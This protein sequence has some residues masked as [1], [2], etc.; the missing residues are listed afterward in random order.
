MSQNCGNQT[1]LHHHHNQT[2][3]PNC[4]KQTILGTSWHFWGTCRAPL[5]HPGTPKT[6]LRQ[7]QDAP[8]AKRSQVESGGAKWSWEVPSRA[9]ERQ[10]EPSR[11]R[12][13][14]DE[15]RQWNSRGPRL[16]LLTSE[17]S[18][19]LWLRLQFTQGSFGC[20]I[21]QCGG[22]QDMSL[23]GATTTPGAEEIGKAGIQGAALS[24]SR[25]SKGAPRV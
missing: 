1:T 20:T 21:Q 25:R 11:A 6:P 19:H 15:P 14:Q 2:M 12:R 8:R 3:L 22:A 18:G 10:A 24:I 4:H 7:L 17:S 16:P 5:W 23:I 9:R 13:S